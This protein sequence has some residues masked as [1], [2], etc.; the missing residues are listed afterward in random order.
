MCFAV[1]R[2]RAVTMETSSSRKWVF[3]S[4]RSVSPEML[5]KTGKVH[6]LHAAP[7]FDMI[8][9]FRE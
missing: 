2:C 5:K 9:R 4:E 8:E 1:E 7:L 3:S 6:L